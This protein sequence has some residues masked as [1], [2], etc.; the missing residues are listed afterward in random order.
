MREWKVKWHISTI[1]ICSESE[2]PCISYSYDAGFNVQMIGLKIRKIETGHKIAFYRQTS[3]PMIFNYCK[4]VFR[5][6]WMHKNYT[7]INLVGMAIGIA[8]M[9]WAF[10]VYRYAFSFDN[11]HHD[12][13][14]V[15]RALTNKKD[16]Q[17]LQ[18]SFP[19][20][21][22]RTAANEFAG[23]KSAVCYSGRFL[24]VRYDNNET[25]AEYVHFTDPGFFHL[26][27]FPLIA[28]I[29]D[30]NDPV[31]VLLTEDMARKYFGS[32]DPIGKPLV[33]Y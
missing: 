15:Y 23:I 1:V 30:I 11:F 28:G 25:F 19:M 3:F 33:L 20:A 9:V 21:A 8:A 4:I 29:C 27:N 14:H 2:H 6:L 5:N 12:P 10:Q 16:V 7:V 31:S 17:G 32:Q 13:D 18:G 24:N 26:F 22:V